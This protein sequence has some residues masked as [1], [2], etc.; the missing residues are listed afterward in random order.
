M[1][2]SYLKV[3]VIEARDLAPKDVNGLSDPYAIIMIE[4]QKSITKVVPYTLNPVWNEISTLYLINNIILYQIAKSQMA[5]K[6]Y[7]F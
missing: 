7:E 4:G 1:K 6:I 5:G 3:H 2:G